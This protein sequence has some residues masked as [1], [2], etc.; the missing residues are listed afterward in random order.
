MLPVVSQTFAPYDHAN[1]QV[2]LSAYLQAEGRSH[3]LVGLTGHQRHFESLSD[4]VQMAQPGVR[5]GSVDL[6]TLPIGPDATLACVQ[7]GLFLV[8]DR[9]VPLVALMR[10]PTEFGPQ[11]TVTLELLCPDQARA[12]GLL[13]EIRRLM[14]ERNVFRRQVVA[15]GESH[16]G[17]I[18]LGPVVFHRRPELPRDA[19]VLPHGVL[20][21]VER[22]VLGI[23]RHREQLRA[24]RQHVKRGLLLYGPPGNGKTLTVR[25]LVSQARDHTV[26]LLT[27]GA[28]HLLR[29]ACALARM[30]EPAVVVLEDV[31]LVAGER[32]MFGR[33]GNPVLFDLLNELDGMDED[34]DVAFV[35]TTNRADV[36]EPALAARPGR[37]DLAVEI[38]LPDEDARRRLVALYGSGVTFLVQDLEATVTRTAGVA[39]SFIK[40]L[41]R[42]AALLAAEGADGAGPLTV[43]DQHLQEA[44][45]ELLEERSALTRVLLGGFRPE[46]PGRRRDV[47]W[48]LGNTAESGP[49]RQPQPEATTAHEAEGAHP[50]G[51]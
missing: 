27:G 41:V 46:E 23:A 32:G 28:L 22:Q 50:P 4:L 31:D 8:D 19:L 11:Q 47:D 34:A 12:N 38:G 26:L 33:A 14:V 43:T 6:V 20:E 10:G 36:L 42:K 44:L 25:Y 37:V 51:A 40:E 39:A 24:S 29:P 1:V 17:H 18:G 2:A 9:G 21:L 16:L 7:F 48:L 5:I 15:F 13:A 49:P 35:L 45:G 30:L 3:E